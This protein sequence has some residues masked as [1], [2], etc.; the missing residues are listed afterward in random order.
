MNITGHS[1]EKLN[2]PTG[3]LAGERFEFFLE[4][5][6]P[7][8]DDLF[9]ENGLS[10]RVIFAIDEKGA[11][12]SQYNFIEQ[13]TNQ[14]LDFALEEEEETLVTEYCAQYISE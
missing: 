12:I 9:S 13:N 5:D 11:R 2:D 6:I 8:D 14:G 1:V 7:E 4:V 10:L 3:I